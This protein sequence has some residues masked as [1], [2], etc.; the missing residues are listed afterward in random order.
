MDN[1]WIL[2]RKPD[3]SNVDMDKIF[4]F[5]EKRVP[6][7]PLTELKKTVQSNCDYGDNTKSIYE[8]MP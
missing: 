3:A 1:V 4:K 7:Y 8:E 2:A 5:I 6:D